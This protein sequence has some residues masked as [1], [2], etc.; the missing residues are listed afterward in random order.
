M[1]NTEPGSSLGAWGETKHNGWKGNEG[2]SDRTCGKPL[3]P[4]AQ[5]GSEMCPFCVLWNFQI[6]TKKNLK[7]VGLGLFRI[8]WAADLLRTFPI[9]FPDDPIKMLVTV[10]D[11]RYF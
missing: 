4:W 2:T 3:F 11:R 6:Q 10:L 8:G 1:E 9:Q 7:P 5:T